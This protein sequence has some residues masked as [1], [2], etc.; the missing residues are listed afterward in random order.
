MKALDALSACLTQIKP[1]II[2]SFTLSV[3]IFAC[4]PPEQVADSNNLRPSQKTHQFKGYVMGTQWHAT[5]VASSKHKAQEIKSAIVSALAQVDNLMSTYKA[6]SEVSKLNNQ[7]NKTKISKETFFVLQTALKIAESSNGAFDP[8]VMPL[9]NLWG[10]G[11]APTP[12]QTPAKSTIT[13]ILSSTGWD[14]IRL[15]KSTLEVEKKH[16]DLQ[17]DLSAIAK[18]YGCD[19]AASRLE[20]LGIKRY[21]IEVGGEIYVKGLSPQNRLWRLAIDSPSEKGFERVIKLNSGGL[22]TSGDYRNTRIYN[23]KIY[24]HTI[25]PRN[26]YPTQH[27]LASV[28]VLAPTCVEAD[29]IATACMVLGEEASLIWINSLQNTEALFISRT[30]ENRYLSTASKGFPEGLNINR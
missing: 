19:L 15:N 5:V 29:A 24:S 18:G 11:P 7:D 8:T 22:A 16:P 13:K 4:A 28:T 23:G 21:M 17:I 25:D 30:N 3:A 1:S 6:T 26:G 9:V 14:K 20:E 2:L 12:T 10:F 27:N